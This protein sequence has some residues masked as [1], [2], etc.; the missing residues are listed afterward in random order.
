V[1]TSTMRALPASVRSVSPLSKRLAKAQGIEGA[2]SG[3]SVDDII[4]AVDFE[5]TTVIFVSNQ[6]VTVFQQLGGIWITELVRRVG[7]GAGILPDDLFFEVDFDMRLLAWS[8]IRTWKLGRKVDCTGGVQ[9]VG[10]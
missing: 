8:V 3:Q 5:G 4:I 9:Q 2:T 7:I 10:A 6:Y 1:S